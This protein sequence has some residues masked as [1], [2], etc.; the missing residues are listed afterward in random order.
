MSGVEKSVRKGNLRYSKGKLQHA[1]EE[2][3]PSALRFR[4]RRRK[5]LRVVNRGGK[6]GELKVAL[7]QRRLASIAAMAA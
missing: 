5:R 2:M 3:E 1:T 7:C 6:T 4:V